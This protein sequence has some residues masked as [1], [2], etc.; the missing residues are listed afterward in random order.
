MQRSLLL[1]IATCGALLSLATE[2][3]A[4]RARR[5]P[6]RYQIGTNFPTVVQ[7]QRD[8]T[9]TTRRVYPGYKSHF[10]TPAW[11]Y[12]GYPH[13]GDGLVSPGF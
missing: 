13:S 8:G 5:Y 3:Q 1:W 12:Y 9:V 11:L 10:P 4:E 6:P 7:K 2:T